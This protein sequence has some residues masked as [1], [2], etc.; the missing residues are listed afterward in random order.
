MKRAADEEDAVEKLSVTPGP[1]V[2]AREQ[3][4]DLLEQL[5]HPDAALAEYEN[6]L[7][8]SPA[9]RGAL[10]G[11]LRSARATGLKDKSS[12]YEAALRKLN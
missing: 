4:G 2:P 12:Y 7:R 1:V 8:D 11:A 3:L 10:Q 5:G 6:A 9:R